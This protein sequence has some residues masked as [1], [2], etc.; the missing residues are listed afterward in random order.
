M[1]TNVF[2]F[3]SLL[4]T[5][6]L[7]NA[8]CQVPA[9]FCTNVR[10]SPGFVVATGSTVTDQRAPWWGCDG[11]NFEKLKEL[12]VQLLSNNLSLQFIFYSF[13]GKTLKCL[14]LAFHR[15]LIF[16]QSCYVC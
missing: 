2:N 11:L 12:I 9:G 10:T 14:S 4:S 5:T 6:Q 3:S 15:C 7:T 16:A 1:E 8:Q 13:R